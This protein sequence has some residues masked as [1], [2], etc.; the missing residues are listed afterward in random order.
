MHSGP[1]M[2]KTTRG[3]IWVHAVMCSA[4]LAANAAR[5][6]E[7]QATGFALSRFE[8]SGRGSHFFSTE[9]LDWRDGPALGL[10][11][12]YAYRPLVVYQTDSTGKV[13]V[14]T[15][16]RHF[17]LG[18]LG[19]TWS[20]ISQL[21]VGAELPVLLY[22]DGTNAQVGLVTY[23]A[24]RQTGVGDL[25]V[26]GDWR[27]FGTAT[28]MLRLGVGVKLFLP[29]GDP[30][31]YMGESRLRG[32]VNVNAAGQISPYFAWSTRLGVHLKGAD[33]TYAGGE[34]GSEFQF[35]L[36]LGARL[37]DGRLFA[38]PE[39]NAATT[40]KNA[41]SAQSTAVDV[42][43]GAHLNVTP[44]WRVGAGVGRGATVALGEPSFRGLLNVE[45]VPP[46][47]AGCEPY[48]HALAEQ[49]KLAQQEAAARAAAE[50]A[51]DEA[52]AV[53][54]ALEAAQ[55]QRVADAAAAAAAAAAE[56]DA[57]A[58]QALADDDG[59]G[60]ANAQDACPHVAGLMIGDASRAGC[61][62]GAVVNGQLVLDLVRFKTNSDVLLS[63]STD[64]LEKALE[65]IKKLPADYRYRIEGHT[66][67][68]GPATFNT[69]LSQRRAKSVVNWFAAHGLDAK[70]FDA[71]GFG[72]QRPVAANDSEEHRQLN[73]RVE[74]H[75][76]NLENH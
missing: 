3:K 43:F 41:M 56:A 30:T 2:E 26:M 60:V 73:R 68:R 8:P 50:V 14:T 4:L 32:T 19:G 6:E 9:S 42:L 5:A 18:Y 59:D 52:R 63:E 44:Q 27:F 21:R 58:Q 22:G 49:Q 70:R 74:I 11:G 12:D 31:A 51:A 48:Q 62:V 45:W 13:D 15:V 72:P 20:P 23:A 39:L 64:I 40:F 46:A 25:R 16:A 38:G 75:I 7:T 54:A 34:V 71:A 10:V 53:R 24:P 1:R 69:D 55:A 66:D 35:G 65:A 17:A 33:T 76:V 28:S 61:P 29:T 47:E 67:D 37:F 57:A 36:A